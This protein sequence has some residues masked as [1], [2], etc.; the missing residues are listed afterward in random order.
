MTFEKIRGVPP[1]P[2]RFSAHYLD[3]DVDM[4]L[5]R[6]A[7]GGPNRLGPDGGGA[8]LIGVPH[9]PRIVATV[10]QRA[11]RRREILKTFIPRSQSRLSEYGE[12]RRRML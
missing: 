7:S 10:V 2:L 4:V 1:P 3:A 6:V 8:T 9:P 12:H 11:I 5:D